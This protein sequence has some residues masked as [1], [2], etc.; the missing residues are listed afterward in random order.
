MRDFS[1]KDFALSTMSAFAWAMLIYVL[2]HQS[3]TVGSFAIGL[4]SYEVGPIAFAYSTIM[5]LL[6]SLW[7]SFI[8]VLA[9]VSLGYLTSGSGGWIAE[10]HIEDA[11]EAP[12]VAPP[13]DA[14]RNGAKVV[15]TVIFLLTV[16]VANLAAFCDHAQ[17]VPEINLQLFGGTRYVNGE[18]VVFSSPLAMIKHGLMRLALHFQSN[19]GVNA[20]KALL[21]ASICA[22]GCVMVI[23]VLFLWDND[24]HDLSVDNSEIENAMK[25]VFTRVI[26]NTLTLY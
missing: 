19:E 4:F 24:F 25:G 5:W 14:T 22:F 20:R 1:R 26:Y 13:G 12:L 7:N 15:G 21:L 2:A 17:L 11:H 9:M 10:W 3:Q 23:V 18:K 6:A 8:W 16:V